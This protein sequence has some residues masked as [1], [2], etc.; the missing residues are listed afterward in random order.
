MVVVV[1]MKMMRPMHAGTPRSPG[2]EEEQDAGALAPDSAR[3]RENRVAEPGNGG[4]CPK[5]EKSKC[6]K[7]LSHTW[8]TR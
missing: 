4:T 8:S 5:V 6:Y 2:E 1:V 7:V 3:W